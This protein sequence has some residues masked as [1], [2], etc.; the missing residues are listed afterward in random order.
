M[1]EQIFRGFSSEPVKMDF[2]SVYF[3]MNGQTIIHFL[4]ATTGVLLLIY[5]L[6]IYYY[7]KSWNQISTVPAP[8]PQ[9]ARRI[10]VSVIIPARNEALNIEQ[11][12]DS[13]LA[14]SYPK[15][16]C[17]IIVVNDFS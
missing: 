11:C 5:A 17:E 1:K 15:E 13:L 14:Q 16:Y 7:H 9:N 6:L 10:K 3:R 8:M 12:L 4:I 2:V